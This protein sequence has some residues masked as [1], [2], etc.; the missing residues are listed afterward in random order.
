MSGLGC[1]LL[2]Y[3]YHFNFILRR[4]T[5]LSYANSLDPDQTPRVAASDLGLHC[6][7]VPSLG[8]KP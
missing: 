5:H 2:V 8:R 1:S 6:L 7:S 3:C 4:N